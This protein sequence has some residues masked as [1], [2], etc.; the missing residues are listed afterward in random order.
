MPNTLTIDQFE[1]IPETETQPVSQKTVLNVNDFE[2]LGGVETSVLENK[3]DPENELN[4]NVFKSLSK[5]N[6]NFFENISES[7]KRGNDSQNLDIMTYE[8]LIGQQ[9][10]RQE[11]QPVKRAFRSRVEADPIKGGN[12]LSD[13]IRLK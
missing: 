8:S 10:Y 6:R 9:D 12:F 7:F 13:A 3:D 2:T 1:S 4:R 5:G 11:I